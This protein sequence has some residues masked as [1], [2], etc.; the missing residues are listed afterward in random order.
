MEQSI[1]K[2]LITGIGG[3]V[4]SHLA[5]YVLAN[6]SDVQVLGLTR[7]WEPRE[8]ISHILDKITLCYADLVDL[9]SLEKVLEEHRPDVIFHLAAQSYVDFSFLAPATTLETNVIGTCNLLE[10]VKRLKLSSGYDPVVHICSCYDQ[11][12]ELLTK[13]GFLKFN[14]IKDDDLVVSIDPVTKSVGY[15]PIG[16][17]IVQDYEGEMLQIKTRSIDLLVTPNHKLLFSK[18]PGQKLIFQEASS[19]LKRKNDRCYFPK[20]KHQG[21]LEEKI[22]INRKLYNTQDIFYL[23]GLYLGDG[24]SGTLIGER[25]NKSGLGRSDFLALARNEKGKFKEVHYDRIKKVLVHSHRVFLAI[26]EGDRARESAV[27]CLKRMGIEYRLYQKEIYFTSRDFVEFFDELGHSAKTKNIPEWVFDYDEKYLEF[28]YKGLIDSD[29][30][31]YQTGERL[32]TVSKKLVESFIKLCL[33]TGRFVTF[34]KSKASRGA[35]IKNRVINSSECFRFS[36]SNKS[37]LIEGENVISKFYKGKIWCL[38]VEGTHNFAVRRNGKTVFCGNSS[39]VYGQ[40]KEDEVPIKES[41]P[42]RPASPYAVSKVGEDMLGLQYWL[43]WKVKT[44]RTRMFTHS[45]ARRGEFF[46]ESN[47]AKQIAAIEAGLQPKVIKVGNLDSVRTFADVRDAVHAY[48]LLVTKCPPGDVYNIGGNRTMTVGEMLNTL[49]GLSTV[50]DIRVEVDP[51]RLRPSD[52][53]LQIPCNDK[54]V[55]AT[56]WKPEVPFEKTMEDLLNYWRDYYKQRQ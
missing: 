54:F 29:G 5:E 48:W 1:K 17:V 49:I 9:A 53:T 52:V 20:G 40:V 44:I 25:N 15:K 24:Y 36:V 23:L 35:R 30:H 32:A 18:G 34:S 14:E 33:F 47:F 56:G 3:F 21:K 13:R 19:F 26:P 45:G 46:S 22:K 16:K 55:A 4:G 2:V 50:K 8:N 37:R 6:H 41:N 51:A 42:F 27:K 31:Y 39:E 12:T 28:L 10:A 38:E 11:E 43:S 7:W